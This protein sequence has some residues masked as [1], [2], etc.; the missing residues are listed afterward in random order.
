MDQKKI[1]QILRVS[2]M[3]Y[4][5]DMGQVEIAEKEN[6]SKSTV[7]RLLKQGKE[8]GLIEVRIKEPILSFSDLETQLLARYP[9]RRVIIVPDYVG[10]KQILTRD[11]CTAAAEDLPK[12][13]DDDSILGVA[14]GTTLETMSTLLSPIRRRGVSVIQLSGS[15]SRVAHESSALA[16]LRNFADSLDGTA[17]V[18]PAPA[19]V[20]EPFIADAIKQD[21]QVK[22]VLEMAE[23]C[24][25]AVFSVGS[26]ARPS[27]MYE[28]GMVNDAQYRD[29]EARG[30]VGDL[31]SH[32]INAKGQSFDPEMER[33]VIGASLTTIKSIPNKLLVASG[34][35]KAQVIAAALWGGLATNLYI[36]A[37]TAMAVLK[38]E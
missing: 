4:E 23:R 14:W 16:I 34:T 37:P 1:S 36:D 32:F 18:I 10:N 24:K 13:L 27:V 28:M 25:T 35:G 11:V 15:Y 7:S 2:K 17:W 6:I 3:Y 30:C 5:L 8:L 12:Y 31:S 29:M 9:L 22:Q 21:S 20:D 26:L 19:M 33:R 38:Q